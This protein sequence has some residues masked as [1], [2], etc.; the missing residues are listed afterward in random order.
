MPGFFFISVLKLLTFGN[1]AQLKSGKESDF[2]NGNSG[3]LY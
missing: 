2:K 3:E 1:K